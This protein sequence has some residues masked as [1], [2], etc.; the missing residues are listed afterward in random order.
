MRRT[1]TMAMIMALVAAPVVAQQGGGMGG[2]QMGQMGGMQMGG[3]QAGD[4]GPLT[5]KFGAYA[6]A[7]VL[8]MK[9]HLSLTADQ[10]A[11]LNAL[12]EEG[13]KAEMEAH[14]PAHAAHMELN[15]AMATEP[16]DLE[17]AK[18]MFL[19]HHNAEGNMQWI[20]VAN[21]MQVKALLTPA[22]RTH[23]EQMGGTGMKH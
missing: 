18:A 4:M 11:R 2:M 21:A 23:V 12:V 15:K 3:Q 19:A 10:E 13:K 16:V 7:K 1:T 9:E 14:M 8:A 20:R 5:A 22:Q 6:P 17:K